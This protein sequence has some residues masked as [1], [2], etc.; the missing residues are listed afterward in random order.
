M[1]RKL[2]KM[3]TGIVAGAMLIAGTLG[4][5]GSAPGD[6]VQQENQGKQE[7]DSGEKE[8]PDSTKDSEDPEQSGDNSDSS[9][10]GG[11][12]E[13]SGDNKEQDSSAGT[14]EQKAAAITPE[15]AEAL[16][17]DKIGTE[18]A[19]TGNT[20]S[21][22]YADECE[23]EGETYY[24]FVWSWLVDDH[25]SRLTDLAV[26]ADGTEAYEAV[27]DGESAEIIGTDNLLK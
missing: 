20:Y 23:I 1:K 16:L 10:D 4:G 27:Y 14:E 5:C 24:I 21:F 8:D 6:S 25:S 3:I 22:G 18:D 19:E 17:Y 2:V 15:E 12:S 26:K 9:K 7:A 13:Q 11:N